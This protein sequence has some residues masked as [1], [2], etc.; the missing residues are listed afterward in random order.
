CF[1]PYLLSWQWQ[2]Y[3]LLLPNSRRMRPTDRMES[4]SVQARRLLLLW[5]YCRPRRITTQHP[6]APPQEMAPSP[7]PGT[8][9]PPSTSLLPSDLAILS[10][11]AGALI[12]V[13]SPATS[14]LPLPLPSP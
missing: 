4:L 2:G 12:E 6:T 7:D 8:C 1:L 5:P 3:M 14:Q 11:C 10:A 13:P 9:R